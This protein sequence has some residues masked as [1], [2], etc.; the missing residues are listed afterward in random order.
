MGIGAKRA[1]EAPL[2][3]I[4]INAGGEASVVVDKV[5]QGE[6]N[7]GFNGIW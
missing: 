1:M 5:K 7:F 4:V 2:R 6:G 3:Q